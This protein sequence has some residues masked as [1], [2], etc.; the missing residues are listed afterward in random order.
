MAQCCPKPTAITTVTGNACEFNVNQVHRVWPVRK[1]EVIWDISTPASNVPA[2]LTGLAP[3]DIA[4]W[5]ILKVAADSTKVGFFPLFG[6]DPT[7]EPG[8]EIT[9]GGSSNETLNGKIKHVAYA[10]SVFSARYDGLTP[11]QE[12]D[13]DTYVCEK[14]ELEVYFIMHDGSIVG[15]LDTATSNLF[16]GIDIESAI[17]LLGRSVQGFS[18]PDSN[19]L[20]FQLPRV[21]SHTLH[22]ITPTFDALDENVI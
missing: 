14:D 19:V 5:A 9:F 20:N 21:W 22:K 2:S 12:T 15:S 11:Q 4:G 7:V 18:T 13:I 17:A 16:T 3:E 10:P 8:E 1:G 6:G